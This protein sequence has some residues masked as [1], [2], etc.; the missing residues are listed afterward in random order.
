[1]S[2]HEIEEKELPKTCRTIFLKLPGIRIFCK[3][4]QAAG[5][6]VPTHINV[7]WCVGFCELCWSGD[8]LIVQWRCRGSSDQRS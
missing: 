7:N 8:A 5:I 3:R 2:E 6:H 4:G 1:M